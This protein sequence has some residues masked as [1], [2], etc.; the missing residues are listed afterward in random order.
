MQDNC[1][2][3]G[4]WVRDKT[5]GIGT[6]TFYDEIVKYLLGHGITVWDQVIY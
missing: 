4:I 1:Y 3:M 2:R 6:L 5:A